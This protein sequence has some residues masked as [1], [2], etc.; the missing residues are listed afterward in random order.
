MS[1][2]MSQSSLAVCDQRLQTHLD[3]TQQATGTPCL[4]QG[5]GLT[6]VCVGVCAYVYVWVGGCDAGCLCLC[7]CLCLFFVCVC[8][9]VY[10]HIYACVYLCLCAY[11]CEWVVGVRVFVFISKRD[12]AVKIIDLAK[13]RMRMGKGADEKQKEEMSIHAPLK[14]P[15]IVR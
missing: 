13:M 3:G 5:S 7:L 11:M 9:H 15:N 10:V 14:H 4:P 8:V 2:S 1:Q 6:H 12:V